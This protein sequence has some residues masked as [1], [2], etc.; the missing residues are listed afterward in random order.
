MGPHHP[1]PAKKKYGKAKTLKTLLCSGS[2]KKKVASHFEEKMV[3]KVGNFK[4]E[5][6]R[7]YCRYFKNKTYVNICFR[8]Q[9][10]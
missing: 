2:R 5:I 9:L 4:Y 7:K 1:S 8:H 10:I 3:L 6:L